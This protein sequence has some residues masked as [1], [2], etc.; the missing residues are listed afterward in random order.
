MVDD[1]IGILVVDDHPVLRKGLQ[2]IIKA[3]KNMEVVGE[4]GTCADAIKLC[5]EL[6]PNVVILDLS[7]PDRSGLE[8]IREIKAQCPDLK[9]LVF[10]MYDDEAYIK[11]VL[12]EGGN[13][14]LLKRAADAELVLAIRAI[15]RGEMVLDT[16]LTRDFLQRLIGLPG[17]EKKADKEGSP[18]S[19]RQ[20]QILCMI[21]Q[22]YTDRQIAEQFHISIKTVESHK[23]R[24]K[25]KLNL[26]H[27][28]DLV[29][30][31]QKSGLDI[32]K[33]I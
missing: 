22:G 26:I 7:L 20:K 31:A 18:L 1:K 2:L 5:R 6:S 3:Q 23:A 8:L 15:A 24:L 30:Y 14:Y 25:E 16:S 27:R 11:K 17:A 10:T 19:S 29:Q 13:G 28:C 33:N 32:S 9:I 12:A 4:A 21:A